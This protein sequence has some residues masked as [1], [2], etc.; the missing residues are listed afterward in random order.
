LNLC[1]E[2][3]SGVKMNKIVLGSIMALLALALVVTPGLA[4]DPALC[5]E[6]TIQVSG[7]GEVYATP[8]I[9]TI[10]VG[11]QTRNADVKVA[12]Q[13]NAVITDGM[14]D[15]LVAAGIPREDIQ[16][17]SYSIYPV[18]ETTPVPFGQKIQ[19]YEVTN[20]V[21]V[22]VRDVSRTGEVIDIAVANGAN[23]VNSIVFSL[24]PEREAVFRSEVLTM[25]VKKARADADTLALATSVTITGI[26]TISVGSVYVPVAYDNMMAAE[27]KVSGAPT[28]I[29]PGQIKVSAQVSISYLIS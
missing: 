26:Q 10:N 1:R 17:V 23:Q 8:D 5:P 11:V 18:Y 7:T 12:Q 21:Q 15:T 13:Q 14:I 25:A 9:S 16:T 24:S 28:P 22:M 6:R 19:Y 20:S 3:L 4:V 29:E 27:A 2:Y